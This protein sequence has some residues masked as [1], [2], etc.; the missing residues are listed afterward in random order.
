MLKA[1]QSDGVVI[2]YVSYVAE[3]NGRPEGDLG[4]RG[5]GWKL[6]HCLNRQIRDETL[7]LR[8][9]SELLHSYGGEPLD[10]EFCYNRFGFQIIEKLSSLKPQGFA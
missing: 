8:V 3:V 9:N 1:P 2:E 4:T 7:S 6:S 5:E 10:V